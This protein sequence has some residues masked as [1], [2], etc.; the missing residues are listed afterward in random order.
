[1]SDL[2]TEF[3]EIESD[4]EALAYLVTMFDQRSDGSL[5]WGYD[6]SITIDQIDPYLAEYLRGVIDR[7]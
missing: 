6:P 5:E 4:E 3:Q 1:M 2:T 7:G